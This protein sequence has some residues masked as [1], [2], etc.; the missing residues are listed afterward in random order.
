MVRGQVKSVSERLQDTM[1]VSNRLKHPGIIVGN[2]TS[3]W[4]LLES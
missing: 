2:M 1:G 4:I 3:T